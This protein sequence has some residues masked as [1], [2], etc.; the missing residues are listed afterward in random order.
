[1]EP[2]GA[3]I[4]VQYSAGAGGELARAA[5]T[6][7]KAPALVVAAGVKLHVAVDG[8]DRRGLAPCR[9]HQ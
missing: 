3:L 1:M 8:L 4:P 7:S 5:A 9:L 6:Y 2:D